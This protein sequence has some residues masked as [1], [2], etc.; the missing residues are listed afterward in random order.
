[1]ISRDIG[2]ANVN[3]GRGKDI[4]NALSASIEWTWMGLPSYRQAGA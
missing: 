1:M 3:S 2:C 4:C